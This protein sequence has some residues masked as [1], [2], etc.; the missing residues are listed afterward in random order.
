MNVRDLLAK[1]DAFFGKIVTIE[2]FLVEKAPDSHLYL[3]PD[4]DSRD[5]V[6]NSIQVELSFSR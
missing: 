1:R 6:S 4:D 5:D 2:G 3:A